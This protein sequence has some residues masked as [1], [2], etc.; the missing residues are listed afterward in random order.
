MEI[1]YLLS[2]LAALSWFLLLVSPWLPW[3]TR[4]AWDP[5]TVLPPSDTDLSDITVLMPARNEE[6]VIALTLEALQKQGKGLQIILIDD[7]SDDRTAEEAQRIAGEQVTIIQGQARPSGWS[8]KLW[9]LEQGRQAVKTPLTLLLDADI[10]VSPGLVAGLKQKMQTEERDFVS[11]MAHPPLHTFWDKLLMPAFIYYFKLLYPF[12]LANSKNTWVAAAAGGCVLTRTQVLEDIGG[13]AS[14]RQEVIDDCA[15]ARQVKNAGYH[16][17]LGL[18]HAAQSSRPYK[19]LQEIWDMVARTAYTQLHYSPILLLLCS[20]IMLLVY[21][22]PIGALFTLPSQTGILGATAWLF[23]MISYIP[24]LSY[25]RLSPLW[26]LT[27][28]GI[29]ALYLAMTWTSALRYWRG[30]RLRWRGR[31]LKEETGLSD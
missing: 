25:Y 31:I 4:E 28:P 27:L 5:E 11:L 13:F 24:T 9:A 1:L 30:E 6:Q 29:A 22:V 15:L 12:S 3:L 23:M 16:S 10:R 17:W 19:D 2:C 7:Q 14:I 8:G 21:F 26:A 18:S 20:L